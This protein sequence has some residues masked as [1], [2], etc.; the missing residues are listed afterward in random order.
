MEIQEGNRRLQH[1]SLASSKPTSR[2][3]SRGSAKIQPHASAPL[4][5]QWATSVVPGCLGLPT[6]SHHR[7]GPSGSG[8][9]VSRSLKDDC[10][11]GGVDVSL[12]PERGARTSSA[13][14]ES[15]LDIGAAQ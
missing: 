6:G 1:S 14:R 5:S 8:T 3:D 2:L 10:G 9:P 15:G 4:G 13:R 7:P 12:T 11:T